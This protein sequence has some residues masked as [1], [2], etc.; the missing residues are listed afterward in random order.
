MSGDEIPAYLKSLEEI[1]SKPS[2]TDSATP[3]TATASTDMPEITLS[4]IG[5]GSMFSSATKNGEKK[6]RFMLV[7]THV[8][9]M[10]GYSKVSYGILCELAKQPWLSVTH[11]AFQK[12]PEVPAEFR[13]YPQNI[14]VID[15]MALEKPLQQGF[16]IQALPDVIRR[17]RPHVIMIYNDLSIVARFLE[18]IRKS[19]IP[20]NFQIWVYCDQVYTM[21]SQPLLDVLNRDA[22]RVFAFTPYWKQCLKDQGVTRPIDVL[23]H[24]FNQNTYFPMPKE[25]ARK[26]LQLPNEIFMFMN[27]NRNQ[28]RKRYDILIMAFVELLVKYPTKPLYLL[29]VCDKG[30]RGGWSLFELFQRE[31]RLREVSLELFGNRLIITT[32]NMTFKDEEIN[33]FYNAADVGITTAD[34][35]GFGLCQFEHMGVGVPQVVPNMGGFSEFCTP[36]NSSLVKPTVRYYLP[37]GFSPVGGEANACQPH[38]VCLAM[39][40]YVLNSEKRAQHGKQ[41][42]ATVLSYTWASSC[43]PL[44][45]RLQTVFDEED[46]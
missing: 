24:G 4:S 42:R 39:E 18:E 14:E 30:D 17:K 31:L 13:P 5:F 46:S 20:R 25:L 32:Q 44:L 15:A 38:D 33:L 2:T 11:Y 16:G 43:Q 22:D 36:D 8:H 37:N 26:Q 6:L 3:S 21:Q 19:G 34:G 40:E 1:L 45:K 9:Q 27:L 10:T 12:Q 29:A 35:E 41:A 7:S 28:P 23:L